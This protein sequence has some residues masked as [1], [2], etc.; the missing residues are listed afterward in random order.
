L[1]VA[2]IEDF[3]YFERVF[4]SGCKLLK[5]IGI[6]YGNLIF[7]KETQICTDLLGYIFGN[8]L[9]ADLADLRRFKI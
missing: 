7:K 5:I 2:V 8:K 3:D 4:Q 6:K 1:K 9:Q